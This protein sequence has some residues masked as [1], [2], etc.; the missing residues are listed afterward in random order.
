MTEQLYT[1]NRLSKLIGLSN[2]T[3]NQLAKNKVLPFIRHPKNNKRLFNLEEVMEV[4]EKIKHQN[5]E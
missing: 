2:S 5:H 3:I 1:I 4:L